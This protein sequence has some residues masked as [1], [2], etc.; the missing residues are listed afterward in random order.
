[1]R[2]HR[3]FKHFNKSVHLQIPFLCLG[4][5]CPVLGG[6]CNFPGSPLPLRPASP[7]APAFSCMLPFH[8]GGIRGACGMVRRGWQPAWYY[9]VPLPLSAL[10]PESPRQDPGPIHHCVSRFWCTQEVQEILP[11]TPCE[12]MNR[13][14]HWWAPA[15]Y[16]VIGS[17]SSVQGEQLRRGEPTREAAG[18]REQ[19]RT[20]S[21][22]PC[23]S[24]RPGAPVSIPAPQVHGHPCC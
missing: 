13:P 21:W 15:S 23:L 18:V 9:P 20:K 6:A 24:R 7:W 5:S 12:V 3:R 14:G 1:M 8:T 11:W 17:V 22:G 10:A 4:S 16:D 19:N 2:S